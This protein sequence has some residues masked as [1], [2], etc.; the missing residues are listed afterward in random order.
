MQSGSKAN[1]LRF[2]IIITFNNPLKV[3]FSNKK[4]IL[5]NKSEKKKLCKNIHYMLNLKKIYMKIDIFKG[6]ITW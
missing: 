5:Y 3:C 1:K 2:C 6:I 4:Y